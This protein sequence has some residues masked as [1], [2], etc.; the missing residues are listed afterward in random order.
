MFEDGVAQRQ[1]HPALGCLHAAGV[2]VVHALVPGAE[3]G[4]PPCFHGTRGRILD[5]ANEIVDMAQGNLLERGIDR[6]TGPRIA[7]ALK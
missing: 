3:P 5:P 6:R 1:H 2:N 4:S 7:I